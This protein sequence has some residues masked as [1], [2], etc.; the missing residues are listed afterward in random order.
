MATDFG[1]CQGGGTLKFIAPEILGGN[2]KRNG[3][4]DSYA[5]ANS[6]YEESFDIK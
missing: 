5:F 6:F 2:K 3:K 4:A 1:A